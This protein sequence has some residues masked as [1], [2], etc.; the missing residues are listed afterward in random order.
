M[1]VKSIKRK[2]KPDEYKVATNWEYKIN[3]ISKD[4]LN[5]LVSINT[6]Y[7]NEVEMKSQYKLDFK[8]LKDNKLD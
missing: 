3:L 2:I 8:L 6:I 7:G 4:E 5:L 1:S